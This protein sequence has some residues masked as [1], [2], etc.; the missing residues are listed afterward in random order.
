MLKKS[1][2][3]RI[4]FGKMCMLVS[5]LYWVLTTNIQMTQWSKLNEAEEKNPLGW[6]LEVNALFY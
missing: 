2:M 4:R 1:D 6:V 5:I 3:A